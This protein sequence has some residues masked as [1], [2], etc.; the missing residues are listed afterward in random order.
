MSEFLKFALHREWIAENPLAKMVAHRIR[1]RRTG[2]KTLS[3]GKAQALMEFVETNHPTAVPFFTLCLF[4][5]IRP[6]AHRQNC[7]APARA[8]EVG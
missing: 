8:R 4:A 2:A 1:R 5:G 6:P 3:A 7:P